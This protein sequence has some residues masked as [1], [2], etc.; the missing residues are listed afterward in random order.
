MSDG[1]HTHVAGIIPLANLN[2][3]LGMAINDCLTLVDSGFTAIQKSVFECA[4]AGCQTIWIIANDD[5][6]P[7]IKKLI[8][9][10]VYD[11]VYYSR[12]YTV[13]P[14]E[15]RK[16]IPI[17]YV[18]IHP[19]DRSRRDSYGWSVLHGINS[20]WRTSN[21]LSHWVVPHKYFVTFPMSAYNV[22]A[23]K[24]F[25]A[26]ISDFENNFFLTHEGKTVKDNIPLAFTMFGEDYIHCRRYVNKT[27]TKEYLN[28][29]PDE[30]YPQKKLPLSE[31]W[32]A[33]QFGFD[34]IFA[35]VN[36]KNAH[37]EEL[38]W[39]YDISKWTGYQAFMGS[40]NFIQK[41]SNNLTRA[42][43]H[44]KLPYREEELND[45]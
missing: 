38:E 3:D 19:K 41:P 43:K 7:I 6:A 18:P 17:Y 13:F 34:T 33:R 40:E 10:W 32:S 36:E 4:M 29:G 9:E 12:Q 42:H 30:K 35:K 16:E 24:K 11:P 37:K 2:A 31:R 25:R 23:L 8:G 1:R 44:V 20:A 28:P 15:H 21:I 22:Y 27:T 5:V 39:Y 45:D 26:K 14:S